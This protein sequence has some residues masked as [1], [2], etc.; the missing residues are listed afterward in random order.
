[1]KLVGKLK[2]KVEMAENLVEAKQEIAK[3]GIVLTDEEMEQVSG[4]LNG[5]SN[6]FMISMVT[7][8]KH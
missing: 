1:M 4:G 6:P 2:E 3:A 8:S 7:V 5:W